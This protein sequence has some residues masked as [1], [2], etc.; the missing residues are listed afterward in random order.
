MAEQPVSPQEEP[1]A[2]PESVTV[3]FRGARAAEATL[4][5]GQRLMWRAIRLMG[6]SQPFLNSPWVFY[7]STAATTSQP[8]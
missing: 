3:A 5:W 8:S 6:D 2:V 4:T 1:G 7:L